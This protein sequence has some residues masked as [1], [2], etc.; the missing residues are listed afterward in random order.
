MKCE[1]DPD[2]DQAIV[3]ED[4]PGLLVQDT[5]SLDQ[6]LAT[7]YGT[8]PELEVVEPEDDPEE[9]SVAP[10]EES[11]ETVGETVVLIPEIE[12][13]AE[14]VVVH[15]EEIVAFEETVEHV[16]Q[17]DS[18]EERSE[19]ITLNVADDVI[20][21][22]YNTSEKPDEPEVDDVTQLTSDKETPI[23]E[24]LES[25]Q[26]KEVTEVIPRAVEPTRGFY[27]TVPCMCLILYFPE[28]KTNHLLLL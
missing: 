4:E 2:Q 25:E 14:E 20:L 3:E 19:I 10:I 6:L 17:D 8:E 5:L 15:V 16:T 9:E 21:F 11:L 7:E 18:S 22:D 26:N 12:V 27:L 24:S 13:P 23:S 28:K 1:D